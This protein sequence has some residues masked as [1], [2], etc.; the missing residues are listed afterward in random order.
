MTYCLL[1]NMLLIVILDSSDTRIFDKL[2]NAKKFAKTNYSSDNPEFTDD[3][4]T[5]REIIQQLMKIL[6]LLNNL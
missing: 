2:M 6:L 1:I 5:N 3:I 4:E